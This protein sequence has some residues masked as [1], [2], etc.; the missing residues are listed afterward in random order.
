V[1]FKLGGDEVGEVA[2]GFGGIEDLCRQM[3]AFVDA[4]HASSQKG[5]RKGSV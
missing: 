4:R 3:L 2:K 1:V 5:I